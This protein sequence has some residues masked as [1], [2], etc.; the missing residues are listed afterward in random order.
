ML[1]F[2]PQIC[3][4]RAQHATSLSRTAGEQMRATKLF[5]A[6]FCLG[7]GQGRFLPQSDFYFVVVQNTQARTHRSP[8]VPFSF[9]NL[10]GHILCCLADG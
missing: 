8:L 10:S 7:K 2:F 6:N 5:A 4:T 3:T 9:L 1:V